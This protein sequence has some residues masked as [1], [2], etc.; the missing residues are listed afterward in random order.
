MMEFIFRAPIKLSKPGELRE[1]YES[2]LRKLREEK[3]QEERAP[4][5]LIHKLLL[6]DMEAGKRKMEEQQKN[7]P[8]TLKANQECCPERLS[9]SENEEPPHGKAVHRSAFVSKS[10]T[11]S[12]TFLTGNLHS[13]MERS[14]S[15]NDTVPERA[16]SRL[17][18]PPTNKTKVTSA[19]PG[20]N[21]LA[22]VLLS[23]QNN[24]CLSAPDLAAEKRPPL[25]S[26]SS[27][28]T[29]HKPERSVSPESN[30][31]ISEELNHF[32]PIVCSPCTPPKRLPD[33]RVLSPLIIK[34]TP[35]NL[36]RTLQKQTTYEASP[37]ILKKWEQIFQER[38]IKK[39][40]SK[41][42]LT[43]SLAPEPG[44][45]PS[46][47]DAPR[48][49]PPGGR[50][51]PA[52]GQAGEGRGSAET[53]P[54]PGPAGPRA[55]ADGPAA[56]SRGPEAPGPDGSG[57]DPGIPTAKMAGVG[58]GP[59]ENDPPGPVVKT[60]AKKQAPAL[61]PFELPFLPNGAREAG[62]SLG[63]EALSLPPPPRRGCKRHC[64]TKHLEQNGSLKKLRQA[65][66]EAPPPGVDRRLRQEEEDRQL[67]L[68]LQRL[69]DHE[70]RTISSSS[71]RRKG[72]ADQYLLRPKSSTGAK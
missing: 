5:D 1:E 55:R 42:T 27:L 32:K 34:S 33:G 29:L 19:T 12:L 71:S 10:N 22:G 69:Y 66:G 31:S 17:K 65:S 20:S 48:P 6:E 38:Q 9:D 21:P 51:F 4:D 44:D 8:L 46:A 52:A 59:P 50:L 45:D 58:S 47:P 25:G 28:S 49:E 43:S 24:R 7:E 39:T 30:D 2:Q 15:C 68:Q 56:R 18:R 67:A 37:R 62:E 35:R 57:P 14:Q 13:K 63:G 40:L 60:P 36:S 26:L 3:V 54:G 16:K 53:P 64:K 23:T 11:Y 72:T 61:N 41:A 70:R